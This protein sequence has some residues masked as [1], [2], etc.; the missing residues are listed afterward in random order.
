MKKL[1][2]IVVLSLM[3]CNGVLANELNANSFFNKFNIMY[4]FT[5]TPY[6][7]PD[8]IHSGVDS[9]YICA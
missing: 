4:V 8:S 5:G 3:W 7:K 2:G 6:V 9:K 1:L